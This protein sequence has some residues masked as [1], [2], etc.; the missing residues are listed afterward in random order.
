MA[1]PSKASSL[2][3]PGKYRRTKRAQVP[4]VFA[5]SKFNAMAVQGLADDAGVKVITNLYRTASPIG[6]RPAA[7]LPL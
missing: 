7:I 6:R 4:A 5:E 3:A 1:S 2:K